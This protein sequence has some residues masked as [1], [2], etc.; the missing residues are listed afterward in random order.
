MG[1]SFIVPLSNVV[2]SLAVRTRTTP[3]MAGVGGSYFANLWIDAEKIMKAAPLLATRP[4]PY[5]LPTTH[6]TPS[7]SLII[8][9][10]MH[11]VTVN[12]ADGSTMVEPGTF[13]CLTRRVS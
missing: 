6:S 13:R 8:P 3:S 1:P 9:A 4:V 11:S 7:L 10:P 2:S 5:P 12:V